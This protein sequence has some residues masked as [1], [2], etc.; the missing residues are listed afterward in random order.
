[1]S[2][3]SALDEVEKVF[4]LDRRGPGWRSTLMRQSEM[5]DN[6]TEGLPRERQ[7]VSQTHASQR[8][9]QSAKSCANEVTRYKAFCMRESNNGSGGVRDERRR[10]YRTGNHHSPVAFVPGDVG[11]RGGGRFGKTSI[12]SPVKS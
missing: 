6:H 9:F 3:G 10:V 4:E 12:L 11:S 8:R 5:R 7:S 2:L 1:M